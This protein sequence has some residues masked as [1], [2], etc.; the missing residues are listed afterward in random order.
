MSVTG[1]ADVTT[2][3]AEGDGDSDG[4]SEG[5]GDGESDGTTREDGDD[6]GTAAVG[7]AAPSS[8][9]D[10]AVSTPPQ[11]HNPSSPVLIRTHI[12]W[13]GVNRRSAFA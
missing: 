5:D 4:D 13:P 2:T 1:A 12:V 11:Q 3:F 9:P 7:V 6:N 8:S 10:A